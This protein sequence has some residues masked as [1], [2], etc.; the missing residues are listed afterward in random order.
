MR[1]Q[2]GNDYINA[3]YVD[4]PVGSDQL[5]YIA[6]QGPMSSTIDDHWQMIWEQEVGK[7]MW[8]HSSRHTCLS[9]TL[10]VCIPQSDISNFLIS[11]VYST[12]GSVFLTDAETGQ[13]MSRVQVELIVMVVDCI[14]KKSIKCTQYWPEPTQ[15]AVYRNTEVSCVSQ[16]EFVS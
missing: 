11:S 4:V 3:S 6:S 7:C 13:L 16:S 8:V 9:R 5:S 14:E 2:E 12:D 15:T 1:L 10:N